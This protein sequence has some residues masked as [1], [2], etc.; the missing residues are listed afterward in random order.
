MHTVPFLLHLKQVCGTRFPWVI[1]ASVLAAGAGLLGLIPF[2]CV[3]AEISLVLFGSGPLDSVRSI[4]LVALSACVLRFVLF[5]AASIISH[6]V[7]FETMHE[8][9]KS[10]AAKLIKI[11]RSYLI[12]RNSA[13]VKKVLVQD[14]QALDLLIGHYLRDFAAG[15]C[16]PFVTIVWMWWISPVLGV[17]GLL[18][19]ALVYKAFRAS[20]HGFEHEATELGKADVAMQNSLVEFVRGI[21]VAKIFLPSVPHMLEQRVAQYSERINAWIRRTNSPW[22]L[23]N[24]LSDA[25]LLVFVPVGAYLHHHH[26]LSFPT[27][28]LVLLLCF[29]YLQPLIRLSIQLGLFKRASRSL[30][31]IA[32]LLQVPEYQEPAQSALPANGEISFSNVSLEVDGK[33]ILERVS[34]R[35]PAGSSCAIV[36]RSG[37]GKTSLAH[38]LMKS[39]EPSGG[40]I[41]IGGAAID[42]LTQTTLNSVLTVMLQD[43]FLFEGSVREN[44]L[45]GTPRASTHQIETAVRLSHAEDLISSFPDRYDSVIGMGGI[46]LSG[47]ERQRL[48]L[49]RALLRDT[50]VLVLDETTSFADALTEQEMLRGIRQ[51]YREKTLILIAHRLNTIRW[52]DQIIVLDKGQIVGMGPHETLLS[53]CPVYQDLWFASAHSTREKLLCGQLS[54]EQLSSE[55]WT[56]A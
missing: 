44:L 17:A 4:I 31:R 3:Y 2:A 43:T 54:P 41:S 38:L 46:N 36:G 13:D 47:G 33:Q 55:R 19:L 18:V 39:W 16:V 6:L 21:A 56:S 51:R 45:L 27:F 25:A 50:P 34:F 10:L 9:Q 53:S 29:G 8:L 20:F 52:V 5:G 30:D 49:A 12:R 37:A 48:G 11:P 40:T 42:H 32:E 15:L 35:I 23:F 7:A 22:A 24:I 28:C 1:L 26:A 14:V